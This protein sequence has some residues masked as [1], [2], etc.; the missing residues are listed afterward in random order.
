MR[1]LKVIVCDLPTPA[2]FSI[3]LAISPSVYLSLKKYQ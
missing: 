2:L 1:Y 3:S